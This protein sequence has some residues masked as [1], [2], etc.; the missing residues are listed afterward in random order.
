MKRILSI[1]LAAA[2]VCAFGFS[3]PAQDG[4]INVLFLTSSAGF[5]HAVIKRENGDLGFVEKLMVKLGAEEGIRV[6]PTKDGGLISKETLPLF[7]VVMLY[8]TGDITKAGNDGSI[9]TSEAGR[10]A[11]IEWVAAGGALV[12]THTASD[13]FHGWKP[14]LEMIGGQFMT[15]GKQQDGVLTVKKHPITSHLPEKWKLFEE[16]YCYKNLQED[17][18]PIML[19]DGSQMDEDY[20]KEAGLYP[21]G[22]VEDFGKGRVFHSAL[23]HRQDVWE[24]PDFQ[25]MIIKAIKWTAKK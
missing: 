11:L 10:Q 3:V 13:T 14:Y 21:H 5:E 25:K 16:W 18:T 24:N 8:T 12:G 17:F 9:P 2:F 4:P 1:A 7:D 23:G 15:H 19:L 22:W 20:Y 6:L